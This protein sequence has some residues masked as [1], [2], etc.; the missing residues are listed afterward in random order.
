MNYN[1]QQFEN[2]LREFQPRRPAALPREQTPRAYWTNRLA[3][4]AIVVLALG[5]SVWFLFE[6]TDGSRSQITRSRSQSTS[7]PG[8]ETPPPLVVLTR[9]A[10]EDPEHLD[11]LLDS[12]PQTRLPRFDQNNSALQILAKE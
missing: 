5:A 12:L 4:A 7:P 2:Y 11:A 1:D 3:A 10:A 6:P 8:R 9:Q